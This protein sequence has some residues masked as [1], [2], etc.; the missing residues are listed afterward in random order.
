[1]VSNSLLIWAAVAKHKIL[2]W[3]WLVLHATEW[4]VF[5]AMLTLVVIIMPQMYLK[6]KLSHIDL[7]H[8]VK[9]GFL[10]GDYILG[11]VSIS[12]CICLL[13]VCCEML[14]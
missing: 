13:L 3:P 7:V 9:S 2:L 6:V 4:F 5:V 11:G 10:L 12:G 1:M 14:L 8:F